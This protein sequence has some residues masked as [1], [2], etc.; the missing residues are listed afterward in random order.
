VLARSRREHDDDWL[1]PLGQK[2]CPEG[3]KRGSIGHETRPNLMR[4]SNKL[5]RA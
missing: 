4:G 1:T 5:K 2:L 3:R